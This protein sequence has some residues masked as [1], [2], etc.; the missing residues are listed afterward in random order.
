MLFQLGDTSL[1][2]GSEFGVLA[3]ELRDPSVLVVLRR[4]ARIRASLRLY[5]EFLAITLLGPVSLP[6]NGYDPRRIVGLEVG[7]HS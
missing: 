4:H 2:F 7:F 3:L 5:V 6:V 1:E